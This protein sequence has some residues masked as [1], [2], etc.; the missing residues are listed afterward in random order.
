MAYYPPPCRRI[1]AGPGD[2]AL[3]LITT[4]TFLPLLYQTIATIPSSGALRNISIMAGQ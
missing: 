4:V 3:E 1:A 2:K